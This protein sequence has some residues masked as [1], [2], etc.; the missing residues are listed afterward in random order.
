M[1]VYMY[2]GYNKLNYMLYVIYFLYVGIKY[3]YK[4]IYNN[5]R[6]LFKQLS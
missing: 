3:K 2:R 5:L 6:I 1:Y 4:K